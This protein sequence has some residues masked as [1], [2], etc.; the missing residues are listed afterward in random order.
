MICKFLD[1]NIL[2]PAYQ[3]PALQ[4]FLEKVIAYLCIKATFSI[5]PKMAT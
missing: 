1:L 5:A 4:C 3:Y 2:Y